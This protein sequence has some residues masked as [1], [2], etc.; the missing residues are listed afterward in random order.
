[1]QSRWHAHS[2]MRP[3]MLLAL[4]RAAFMQPADANLAEERQAPFCLWRCSVCIQITAAEQL[5]QT[6]H[7]CSSRRVAAVIALVLR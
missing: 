2:N 6:L 1:M 4:Q 5:V 7:Q 3:R